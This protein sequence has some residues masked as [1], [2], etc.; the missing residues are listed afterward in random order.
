[1]TTCIYCDEIKPFTAEHVVCAGLGG[2]DKD[3]M[4]EYCVCG[5]CNT[6]VFS[7]L[8]AAFLRS[9][10]IALAR[11]F[12]QEKTRGRGGKAGT[13]SLTTKQNLLVDNAT[14]L[15]LTQE[16]G[17]GLQP[18]VLPQLLLKTP[19]TL[20]ARIP[21]IEEGRSF[22]DALRIVMRHGP[23][24]VEKIKNGFEVGYK[25]TRLTWDDQKCEF[26]A[27]AAELLAKP[28]GKNAVWV[29]R[30]LMPPSVTAGLRLTP[31]IYRRSQGELVCGL[32]D[33]DEAARFLSYL[34]NNEG[35]VSIPDGAALTAIPTSDV[36]L[37]LQ[38]RVDVHDRVLTK[39]G[40][41]LIA[42]IFGLNFVRRPE[43]TSAKEYVR[44]GIGNILKIS[45]DKHPMND[46]L[47]S[48]DL[49]G[50]HTLILSGARSQN[51]QTRLLTMCVSL[52]SGPFE[53]FA[54]AEL[55]KD[56]PE[57]AEPVVILVS[58]NENRIERFSMSELE[59]AAQ[60]S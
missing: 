50:V 34:R 11:L 13:P 7:K 12:Y 30:L 49:P 38:I 56:L 45:I 25:A 10:P 29:E 44:N 57:L 27:G 19:G 42:K 16:I 6:K 17:Q 28:P 59:A 26:S 37:S 32:V 55:P 1:M 23:I 53:S 9:S 22:L 14:G 8:E 20:M 5:D 40:I 54:L 51:D 15:L 39:I 35:A 60:E 36:H 47:K 43:F 33:I 31:R 52:Y 46:R 4:L 41:N 24:L 58:Y 48:T 2:D 18:V 21:N 3:W